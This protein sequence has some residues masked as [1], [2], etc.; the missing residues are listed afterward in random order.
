MNELRP[1]K[2][3][4]SQIGEIT[5]STT[6]FRPINEVHGGAVERSGNTLSLNKSCANPSGTET[7]TISIKKTTKKMI[8]MNK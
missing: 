5:N 2:R 4:C 1:V 6:N 7:R 3:R 8:K